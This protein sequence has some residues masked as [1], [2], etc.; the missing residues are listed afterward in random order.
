MSSCLDQSLGTKNIGKNAIIRNNLSEPPTTT[1]RLHRLSISTPK[2]K[3]AALD[4]CLFTAVI[5]ASHSGKRHQLFQIRKDQ[6]LPSSSY[7]CLFQV[8]LP[9]RRGP[10]NADIFP[11]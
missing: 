4:Y 5:T 2:K 8:K 6:W 7:Q 9:A 10:N 11:R 1:Q 3:S